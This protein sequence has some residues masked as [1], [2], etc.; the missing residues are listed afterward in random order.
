MV[1]ERNGSFRLGVDIG[2]TFTDVVLLGDDGAVLTT[3]VLS[4]PDDYARGVVDGAS[5]LLA[6]ARRRAGARSPASSTPPPSPPTRSSRAWARARR[7]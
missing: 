1:Q 7:S 5:A 4:T 3:K 2:G 6:R